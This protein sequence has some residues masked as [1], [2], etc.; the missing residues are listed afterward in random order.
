MNKAVAVAGAKNISDFGRLGCGIGTLRSCSFCGLRRKIGFLFG[1]SGNG[2]VE[3]VLGWVFVS[4]TARYL[5]SVN[6]PCFT[7]PYL[8]PEVALGTKR[9][10]R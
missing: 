3:G 10:N 8:D 4:R 9:H 2:G 6:L 5:S 1:V 7:T